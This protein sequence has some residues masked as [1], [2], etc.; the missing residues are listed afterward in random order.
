MELVRETGTLTACGIM[1]A[2]SEQIAA[3]ILLTREMR[4]V[5]I[6]SAYECHC[7]VQEMGPSH[8]MLA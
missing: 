1:A 7:F 3:T 4:I 8:F 5:K 2:H 6:L